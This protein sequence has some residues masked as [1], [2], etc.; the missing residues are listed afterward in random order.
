MGLKQRRLTDD[1]RGLAE[2]LYPEAVRLCLAIGKKSGLFPETA[3]SAA[4]M[5]CV[6]AAMENGNR[7]DFHAYYRCRG[8]LENQFGRRSRRLD[9]VGTEYDL[10]SYPDPFHSCAGVTPEHDQLFDA[11]KSLPPG[12]WKAVEQ[13]IVLGFGIDTAASHLGISKQVAYKAKNLGL[14]KLRTY[15]QETL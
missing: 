15:F 9:N 13:T 12:Q 1:E 2:V 7:L 4:S 10:D 3:K 8:E 14:A 11:V 5:A 6:D